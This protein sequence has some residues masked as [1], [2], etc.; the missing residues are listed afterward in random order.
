M[1]QLLHNR[2]Y[3]SGLLFAK[4]GEPAIGHRAFLVNPWN[5]KRGCLWGSWSPY[6]NRVGKGRGLGVVTKRLRERKGIEDGS[7]QREGWASKF[8]LEG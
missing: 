3:L 8:R 7:F 4:R 5:P 1:S 6:W 2:G